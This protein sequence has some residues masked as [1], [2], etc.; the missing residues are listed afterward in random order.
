MKADNLENELQNLRFMH[1]TEAE[2]AAYCDQESDAFTSARVEAHLKQCFV[3]ER[4]LELLQE[5]S[6][7][8]DNPKLTAEDIAFVERLME[9]VPDER[10]R[11]RG[12]EIPVREKLADYLRQMVASWQV[13]FEP[14][15]RDFN[16]QRDLWQWQSQDGKLQA[17]ATMEENGDLTI[18]IYS[19]AMELEGT[20]FKV[21]LGLLSQE[22]TL[23][24]ISDSEVAAKV[25]VPW[26]QRQG[27]MADLS[28]E[29]I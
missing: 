1:L 5:E 23:Q 3:C 10:F 13:T 4:Q 21:R 16:V 8:L 29:S 26:Q 19:N 15:R 27:D 28:I 11:E 22:I 6:A 20:R 17:R 25:A 9:Q 2:L 12:G 24:Q 18:H 7:A 14:V